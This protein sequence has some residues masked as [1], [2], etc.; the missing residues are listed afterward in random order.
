MSLYIPSRERAKEEHLRCTRIK[1]SKAYVSDMHITK[2]PKNL[3]KR[4]IP[5]D[6]VP[7]KLFIKLKNNH[8]ANGGSI[9]DKIFPW[10]RGACLIKLQKACKELGLPSYTCHE[11]R[12]TFISN[13]IK[14]GVPL[15]VIEKVSGDTQATI[16]KRYSHMF[17]EDEV[18][19]LLAL[20][21]L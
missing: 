1:I 20:Q 4:T 11:F 21:K 2:D 6:P 14:N 18:M 17:E 9:S 13:L 12:H 16:L 3:K 10:T 19:V 8:L 5:L 7:E 15:P